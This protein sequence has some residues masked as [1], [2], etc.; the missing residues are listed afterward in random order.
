[1]P[2]AKSTEGIDWKDYFYYDESSPTFLRH[3]VNR[4]N[5]RKDT[6]AG[7]TKGKGGYALVKL[8][9]KIYLVHRV[10]WEMFNNNLSEVDKV[11]HKD[12]KILNNSISNLRVVSEEVNQRNRRMP[13]S[14]TTGYIGVTYNVSGYWQANWNPESGKMSSKYF[15]LR[16]Y[17][18]I[19]AKVYAILYRQT[20]LKQLVD[21]GYSERHGC[22]M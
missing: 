15:S 14:N 13:K 17:D 1:M 11:D 7:S 21:F 22:K 10:I 4:L 16:N 2:K 6:V 3:A 8:H 18:Y 20:M 5:V 12:G 19:T 9:H